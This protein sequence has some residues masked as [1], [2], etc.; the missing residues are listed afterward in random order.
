[1]K[2][3]SPAKKY[4][5]KFLAITLLPLLSGAVRGQVATVSTAPLTVGTSGFLLKDKPFRIVSGELEYA[6]IPRPY[7]RDRLRKTHAMGLNAIT[8][9]VFWNI[10]EPTP[11]VYD[12][13]GQNDVAEFV[14]E[15]QQEG[16]YVILR[17][18]PYVCAEWD[19]GGYPAWLLKDH[20]MKLRSL[21]PQ[22]KAAATRWMLRLGQE[23]APLQ[24]SRGGPI[25]AVQVENEY[26]S[27]G[28]DHAYMKW[29]H[30]LVLQAGF[31]GSL[32]YTGDGADVLKQGTLPGVFAG[33]DF[34]TGDAARSIKLYQAFQPNTP[35][36]VAEYWDGWFDHWG[37]KHQLTD[38]AKQE[39]EIRSMLEQGDSISL[40]MVHGGTS[41][42]WMNG[43]NND[44][45]GYQP[46]VS[47]Y[48]YDA[49]LDESGRPRP[50]YFRLRNIIN[51]ITNQ[52]PIPVP[53]SPPLITVPAIHLDEAQSLW[54]TLPKAIESEVPLSMEDVDQNY[55]YIL[56]RTKIN[57]SGTGQLTFN[58]LHSYA[59][60]Y[61]DGKLAGVLDRR[62][63]QKSLPL[64]ITGSHRLDILVENSGRINFKPIIRTERAGALGQ[65]SFQGAALNH[66]S[67]YPLPFA[68][69]PEKGYKKNVCTG[70]CFYHAEFS[71]PNPGDTFLNTEQLVKG[72]VWVNG[73]LLGRFWDIGPAG[74]LYVPGVW[75]HQGKNEL[76]VFDLNGGSGLQVEGQD[77]ATYFE[78][79]PESVTPVNTAPKP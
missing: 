64:Q 58:E 54:S 23:L 32:L 55:G 20:E 62:L 21:Q 4:F 24:A 52:T 35:V 69:P 36:Y 43:A 44:H 56:Y 28:D 47:S 40:Y 41:F 17:P 53:D 12:F 27:F 49:P 61:V 46:D 76:T 79:K 26:G 68:P 8:I 5:H 78:P 13:S 77:H 75:L 33:I 39:T 11:G 50:K 65:I 31:G 2:N 10:H 38:A 22:F 71:T 14:R 3:F 16:L 48:D 29:V 63:G 57:G 18:G 73:H 34:G 37:E 9:Y 51:E 60:I 70:P 45:D 30:E 67:I 72:V 74:A 59:R 66:W 25:L 15:A 42:G 7:W 1:M 6:R 19:L